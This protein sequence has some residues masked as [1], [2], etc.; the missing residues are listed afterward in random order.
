M[1]N[2]H[3]LFNYNTS[4]VKNVGI[5]LLYCCYVFEFEVANTKIDAIC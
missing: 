4:V 5:E 1:N 3:I 2:D